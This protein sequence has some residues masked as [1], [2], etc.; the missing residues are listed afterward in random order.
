VTQDLKTSLEELAD[1]E[2][3]DAPA[4]TVDIGRARTDGRRR[5]IA[6]RVAPLGGGLAV[7]AACA[8]VVNGLGGTSPTRHAVP[9]TPTTTGTSTPVRHFVTGTD[10]LTAVARFGWLPDGYL[11]ATYTSG[12]DYGAGVIART[13]EPRSG[14]PVTPSRLTL[15]SW[16]TEPR[17]G[18]DEIKTSATVAGSSQAYLVTTPADATG[19][20]AELSL[21]WRTGSGS[22]LKLGDY[23]AL[24]GAD[25]KALLIKVA[26]SVTSDGAAVPLPIHIEGLPK[27]VTLGAANLNDPLNVGTDGFGMGLSYRS[28]NSPTT[29]H[30]FSIGV[31]PTGQAGDQPN[32]AKATGPSASAPLTPV[33]PGPAPVC[34][35]S[36]GL[37][38]CVQDDLKQPGP[39]PLASIGGAKGLLDRI[40][41]LGTDRAN[42]TTHVVN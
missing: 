18:A 34:K 6:A 3:A 39:D 4:S 27:G 33:S 7:V 25:L 12:A 22:W 36:E 14:T 8:L 13:T 35:D 41:S 26:D 31:A 38:I 10:P 28:G 5:M 2:Y 30:Y 24:Q 15:T 11:A 29:D 37:H 40:T 16:A 42:W 20:P 1:A 32:P 9:S 19:I 17:L 21:L 23:T